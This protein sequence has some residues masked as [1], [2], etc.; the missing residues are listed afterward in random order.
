MTF[1]F[2]VRF[3]PFST[4]PLNLVRI[5]PPIKKWQ[6]I[7]NVTVAFYVRSSSFPPNLVRIGAIVKKWQ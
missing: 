1:A 7:F 5:G 2:G 6:L 4:F 3:S